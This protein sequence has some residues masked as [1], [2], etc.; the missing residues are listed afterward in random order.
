M[1]V[2]E[3]WDCAQ[4]AIALKFA[5]PPLLDIQWASLKI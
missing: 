5:L 2:E 1:Q 4:I 3:N